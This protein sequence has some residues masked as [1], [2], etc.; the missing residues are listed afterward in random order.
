MIPLLRA[1]AFGRLILGSLSRHHAMLGLLRSQHGLALPMVIGMMM[2]FSMSVATVVVYTSGSQRAADTQ[3]KG[4]YAN[5]AAEAA[6]ATAISVLGQAP[7]PTVSTILPACTGSP[8]GQA[9]NPQ[10]PKA[11]GYYCGALSGSNWTIT[12]TG[13][14]R[15]T[16]TDTAQVKNKV[17]TQV[18]SIVPFYYGGLG[19]L[20]DRLYQYDDT[21]CAEFKKM[22]LYVPI[23]SRGCVKLAGDDAH[24]T[25]LLGPSVAIGGEVDI[26][27]QDSI[28]LPGSPIPRADLSGPCELEHGTGK[29]TPCS[30]IDNVY[31]STIT[32]TP[33][34]ARPTIDFANAYATA[35]PGPMQGCTYGSLGTGMKFDKNTNFNKDNDPQQLTPNGVSYSCEVWSTP[36]NSGTLL[37]KIAWD[38]VNQVF[39]VYG[40]IY[41]DGE[42]K[43]TAPGHS[44]A[45]D[46]ADHGPY[47]DKSYSYNGRGIIYSSKKFEI[48]AGMC[49]GGDGSNDCEIAPSA[50]DP[51]QH[52]L[53][54]VSGGLLNPGDEG[55]KM[56]KDEAV[57]QGAVYSQG[58]CK[59]NKK[60]SI[61]A[62][63]ICGQLG[64]KE[65]DTLDDPTVNTWPASLIGPS[66]NQVWPAPQGE[67][68]IMLQPQLGG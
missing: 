23:V 13:V 30:A 37:G 29:H 32:T 28:G 46:K 59:I 2:V 15:H 68:Q 55:F 11:D 61:S 33:T 31:A 14:P 9:L 56:E 60:A 57:F 58:R 38:A 20:W 62:P 21:K 16:S 24:P 53:I 65:D 44:R 49:S 5:A 51:R 45:C 41:F 42:V 40:T 66:T 47:C 50:W 7:D 35:K 25:R 12:A 18:A 34:F 27:D 22:I 36:P 48:E 39:T 67:L 8:P 3:K 63:L 19:A 43:A 1:N 54:I 6:L 17:I 52:L 10:L 64:I 4:S 26:K